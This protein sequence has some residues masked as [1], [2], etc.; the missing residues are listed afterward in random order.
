MNLRRLTSQ[1]YNKIQFEEKS[2]WKWNT[3]PA[4]ESGQFGIPTDNFLDTT[5]AELAD[6]EGVAP[7]LCPTN[8]FF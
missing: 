8:L 1:P 3:I 2:E 6:T 5:R 7:S 4:I